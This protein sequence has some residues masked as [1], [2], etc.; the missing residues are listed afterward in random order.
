MYRYALACAVSALNVAVASAVAV[1]IAQG[2]A[3][4]GNGALGRAVVVDNPSG[5][6]GFYVT[7]LAKPQAQV[8][9]ALQVVYGALKI[10][11]TATDPNA[12]MVGTSQ[13]T[14]P[15]WLA[16]HELSRYFDCGSG[17]GQSA[18]EMS[19][20]LTIRSTVAPDTTTPGQSILTTTV[21]SASATDQVEGMR[22]R[23]CQT[24]GEL[25]TRIS[26]EVAKLLK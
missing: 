7:A 16:G 23:Q 11:M 8:F 2:Q 26:D 5:G 21:L 14:T 13:W 12:G 25:E 10:P 1:G 24:T 3:A 6:N 19:I 15:H 4:V 18:D 22:S 20:K 9:S 17:R